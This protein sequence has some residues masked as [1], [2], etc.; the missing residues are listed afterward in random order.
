[1]RISTDPGFIKDTKNTLGEGYIR[2]KSVI[3]YLCRGIGVKWDEEVNTPK[4]ELLAQ[5]LFS[6]TTTATTRGY[7]LMGRALQLAAAAALAYVTYNLA[8]SYLAPAIGSN[9]PQLT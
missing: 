2:P 9:F 3:G 5:K 6:K 4:V 8:T 1:M 7:S